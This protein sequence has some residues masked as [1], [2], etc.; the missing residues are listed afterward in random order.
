VKVQDSGDGK[1][2][3]LLLDHVS[4]WIKP[5]QMTALM[6]ASGAGKTT[7]LD[8]L[9]KRKT[10]V[11]IP[12]SV[13]SAFLFDLAKGKVTGTMLLNGLPL[14]ID[15]ERITGYVEQMDVHNP[16]LTVREALRYSA[17]LRQEAEVPEQEKLDYVEQVLAVCI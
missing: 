17:K 3:R 7:L 13:S 12:S 9:V 14:R 15:Y 4:G 16:F 6:G 11:S 2:T 1:K 10:Q 5:G 8:V